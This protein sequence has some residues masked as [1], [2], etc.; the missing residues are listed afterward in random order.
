ML[1]DDLAYPIRVT[2]LKQWAYCP[3]VFYYH[4]CLPRVRPVTYKMR[5]G[6]EA[7]QAEEGREARRSLR[8]YGLSSGDREFD[9]PVRSARRSGIE[10]RKPR[11][12]VTPRI[13]PSISA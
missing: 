2:D 1:D 3:R 10:Y 9:V 13:S 7:G 11:R 4:Q 5:A 8:A 12:T 6:V